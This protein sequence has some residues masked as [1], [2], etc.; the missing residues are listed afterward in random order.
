MPQ[1]INIRIEGKAGRITLNRP[2][3][4]NALTYEMVLEIEAALLQWREDEQVSLVIIDAAGE[5]AF[6]AGGDIQKLYDTGIR[7]EYQFMRIFWRDE[8]RL[9]ALIAS[10]PKPYVAF[11][12]GIVMGGGVGVSAH[13]SHRIVTGRTMLAMPE[14]AIGLVPDV[15]GSLLLAKAPGHVGEL[16]GVS[17]ARLDGADAIHAGFADAL[18]DVDRLDKLK[19]EMINTGEADCIDGY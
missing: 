7:G 19:S 1:D 8:Y 6:C 10:Y 5:K 11:M 14:C 9:N 2:D 18:V 16:M 17:G 15:G 13:G 4:L 12:D 3:S